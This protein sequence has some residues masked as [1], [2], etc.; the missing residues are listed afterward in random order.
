MA[1][2]KDVALRA[3]FSISTVSRVLNN[4]DSLSVPDETRE[5][6]YEAADE[7]NYRKKTV[8]PIVKNIAFL[9]WLSD[10]EELEDVYFKTMRMEIERLGKVFNVELMTYK[11]SEGIDKIP[12][13]IEG[14][15]AVGMFPDR[16]IEALR[17]KTQNGVF[18]DLSPDPKHYD[19]VRPD[20][21]QITK[22]AIDIFMESGHERIGFIGGTYHNPNTHEE[23][24]D[25]REQTF[26]AY[27]QEKGLLVEDYV[28]T[29]RGFSVDNGYQL[30]TNA[31]KALKD[32]LP[33]AFFIAADPIAVGCLQAL[34]EHEISI[35]NRVSVIS[36]NN[37]SVSK[38]VSPPLT[39]FHID[40]KEL[41]KNAMQLLLERVVEKRKLSKTLYIGSEIVMRKSTK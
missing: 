17:R 2:I 29:H 9:Y 23:D 18:I 39:T 38:Y 33:T 7:L 11:V 34:N 3:G 30:M 24:M 16:D 8:R 10:K 31:I 15:I 40:I 1:T 19:S 37:I 5:K 4:D 21:V 26:R 36:V 22:E 12:D 27:M 35:P 14:F 25:I 28:F 20:L 41:C 32:D 13:N 6:I